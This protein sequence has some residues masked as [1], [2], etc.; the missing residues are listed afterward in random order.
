MMSKKSTIF[1]GAGASFDAGYPL[2]SG[3]YDCLDNYFSTADATQKKEWERFKRY[4]S[5]ADGRIGSILKSNN[6]ELVLTLPDLLA[7]SIEDYD[8][9]T[10]RLIGD[11]ESLQGAQEW[12]RRVTSK[13]HNE[14]QEAKQIRDLCLRLFENFFNYLSFKDS[15]N[16]PP[17]YYKKMLKRFDTVIT[18]NWDSLCERTLFT[19][20][21]W[22]PY[23]G[24]GIEVTNVVTK[25]LSKKMIYKLHGSSGWRFD[26]ESNDFFLEDLF[27]KY[28]IKEAPLERQ[29]T[30]ESEYIFITPSYLKQLDN[31]N[32]IKIWQKAYQAINTSLKLSIVGYS[33]P[34]ADVA[35]RALLLAAIGKEIEVIDP[36]RDN[37]E[38]WDVFF[39]VGN[40]TFIPK[41][42]SRYFDG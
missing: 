14:L 37:Q 16:E 8:L 38:K 25:T 32:L 10:E 6:L 42:A 11:M 22:S 29:S 18:T 33:L 13:E 35:I 15:A 17:N 28:L 19:S 30:S 26:S 31:H 36:C 20:G 39:G 3:L 4:R 41:S 12:S 2:T 40:Y 27:K 5:E 9:E 24:Y 1:L 23:N 34:K 7:A 21:Q